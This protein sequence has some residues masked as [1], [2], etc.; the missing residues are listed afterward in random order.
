MQ[1]ML[2]S[3]PL[4]SDS[5][6]LAE[7]PGPFSGG[8]EVGVFIVAGISY[9][10]RKSSYSTGRGQGWLWAGPIRPRR[11]ARLVRERHGARVWQGAKRARRVRA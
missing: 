10:G 7:C 4:M 6:F 9:R 8:T 2:F 5:T 11:G 1:E 3:V